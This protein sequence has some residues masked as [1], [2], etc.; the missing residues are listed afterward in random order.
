MGGQTGG[1]AA[2][3]G[4]AVP[5]PSPLGAALD[6][7]KTMLRSQKNLANFN[8]LYRGPPL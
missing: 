3:G 7:C 8:A 5:R 1:Q 6:S 2:N 4:H